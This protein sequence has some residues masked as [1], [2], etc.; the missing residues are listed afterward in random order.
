MSE[1]PKDPI[2]DPT[3]NEPDQEDSSKGEPDTKQDSAVEDTDPAQDSQIES[4]ASS[5]TQVAEPEPAVASEPA[6]QA[7]LNPALSSEPQVSTTEDSGPVAPDIPADAGPD[8]RN[9]QKLWLFRLAALLIPILLVEGGSRLYWS[10][11]IFQFTSEEDI[12][13][14]LFFKGKWD[15]K[16]PYVFTPNTDSK[17]AKTPT[18][19]N[20][21]GYRGE[22]D[23]VVN[24]PYQ[25]LRVLCVGDS[26]TFGYCVSG[27][28]AA[29]PAVLEQKLRQ[30]KIR[31]QV[32]NGGMPRYRSDHMR[33]MFEQSLPI[34]KPQ[35]FIV[36]GGWNDLNDHVL[37]PKSGASSTLK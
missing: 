28:K 16:L 25:G 31:C 5:D 19:I 23:V 14:E 6:S 17:V 4:P 32:I 13:N 37:R 29:Y 11:A 24:T 27:N 20:N 7:E 21:I 12:Q 1:T 22:E 36:L 3:P 35:V 2:E 34:L 33:F 8:P 9:V 10:V 18:H 26:V 15:K 30:R